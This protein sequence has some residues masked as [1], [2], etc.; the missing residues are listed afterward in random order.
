MI[1]ISTPSTVN[2][3]YARYNGISELASELGCEYIDMNL[4]TEE[5]PIDW[6]KDTRDKGDHLNYFGAKKVTSFISNYL[7]KT[8]LLVS[9]KG[10]S[11]YQKWDE[12]L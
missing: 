2:W 11:D 7:S 9:H 8:K 5:I 1:L 4:M 6:D 3:N 10:D 12:S